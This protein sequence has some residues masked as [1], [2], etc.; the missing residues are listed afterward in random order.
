MPPEE[1]YSNS[2]D[3]P[4]DEGGADVGTPTEPVAP[5][6]Q[7]VS[8]LVDLMDERPSLRAKIAD[9]L[10]SEMKGSASVPENMGAGGTAPAQPQGGASPVQPATATATAPAAPSTPNLLPS[11]QPFGTPAAPQGPTDPV[12]ARLAAVEEFMAQGQLDAELAEAKTV[13]ANL[14]TQ[15]G[16]LL[17]PFDK[18]VE[19]AIG[20]MCVQ[21]PGLTLP[22][23]AQIYAVQQLTG[24]EKAVADRLL[25]KKAL[26][27]KAA[28][29]PNVEGPGGAISSGAKEP[30]KTWAEAHMRAKEH[31]RA[32]F[33]RPGV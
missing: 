33:G 28:A 8:D 6:V 31:L 16:G 25:E 29:L 17:P 23:A 24:G 27:P 21:Y 18:A 32:V 30:P 10:E 1:M 7:L 26:Q 22:Q 20:G 11:P 19:D 12:E 9:L 15:F 14:N 2:P 4:P 13:Y 3:L 5:A